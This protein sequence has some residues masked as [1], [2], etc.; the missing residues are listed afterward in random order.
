MIKTN[1]IDKEW[2]DV[3]NKSKWWGVNYE[4]KL[5]NKQI[6]L[7]P[8]RDKLLTFG[9]EEVCLPYIEDDYDNIMNKGFLID[10]ND[11]EV[12]ELPGIPNQC[13]RNSCKIYEITKDKPQYKD[14]LKIMTGY[15]LSIDGIWVQHTWLSILNEDY[16]CDTIIETTI[17]R[18]AYFG[19]I[20]NDE[21]AQ[22]FCS[23]Y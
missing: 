8:L 4:G 20:M 13:H 17:E 16:E 10:V 19:F 22:E 2:K 14:K 23:W 11:I 1:P 21:E 5:D 6:K 18:I 7:L 3:I 15:A 12:D 9:G